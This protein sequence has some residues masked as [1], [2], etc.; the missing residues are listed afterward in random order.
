MK[1]YNILISGVLTIDHNFLLSAVREYFAGFGARYKV[2]KVRLVR[3]DEWKESNPKF[4]CTMEDGSV[5]DIHFDQIRD[6]VLNAIFNGEGV[7]QDL[8][9][10]DVQ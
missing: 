3:E 7:F 10:E 1:N 9:I 6:K 8:D 4:I 5:Q 2:W